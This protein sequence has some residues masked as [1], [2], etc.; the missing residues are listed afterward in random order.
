M[1]GTAALARLL[2]AAT[3]VAQAPAPPRPQQQKPWQPPAKAQWWPG[4]ENLHDGLTG[5]MH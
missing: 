1:R 2:A 3:A 5:S 4:T